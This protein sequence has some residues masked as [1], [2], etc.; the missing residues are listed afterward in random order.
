LAN[1]TIQ[2]IQSSLPQRADSPFA[3]ATLSADFEQIVAGAATRPERGFASFSRNVAAPTIRQQQIGDSETDDDYNSLLEDYEILEKLCVGAEAQLFVARRLYDNEQVVLKIYHPGISPSEEVVSRVKRVPHDHVVRVF[4]F[5]RLCTN[6]QFFEVQE[7]ISGNTLTHVFGSHPLD[8]YSRLLVLQQSLHALAHLHTPDVEGFSIVHRDI[9]PDNI[10]FQLVDGTP[11]F[12]LCDFGIA[13]AVPQDSEQSQAVKSCTPRYAAPETYAGIISIKV[14]FWALGMLLLEAAT[15]GHPFAGISETSIENRI[16]NNWKPDFAYVQSAHWRELLD[17]LLKHDPV[18][19]WGHAEVEA[20]LAAEMASEEVEDDE[21]SEDISSDYA[22]LHSTTPEELAARLAFHW[23][24][25]APLLDDDLFRRWLELELSYLIPEKP[26]TEMLDD[27]GPSP[28]LRLLRLVYRI[29]TQLPPGWK[30]WSLLRADF[31]DI[32]RH[33][34]AGNNSLNEM[35]QELFA[36]DVLTEL[37]QLTGDS[38][39]L[40]RSTRWKEAVAEFSVIR[41]A[42]EHQG[43]PETLLPIEDHGLA[44]LYL[45]V[46]EGEEIVFVDTEVSALHVCCYPWLEAV[47]QFSEPYSPVQNYIKA[48]AMAS[49]EAE[50]HDNFKVTHDLNAT[51]ASINSEQVRLHGWIPPT[52]QM[53]AEHIDYYM[54]VCQDRTTVAK[55]VRLS[56]N[57]RRAAVV[58]LTR[59]GLVG[60]SGQRPHERASAWGL[61]FSVIDYIRQLVPFFGQIPGAGVPPWSTTHYFIDSCQCNQHNASWYTIGETTTFSLVAIGWGGICVHRLPPIVVPP[62]VLAQQA[63]LAVETP[64]L[65]DQIEVND[66]IPE[67]VPRLELLQAELLKYAALGKAD[68]SPQLE[69]N[70]QALGKDD[71]QQQ[72]QFT[73]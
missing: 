14:D 17:G 28:D 16:C 72:E 54:S 56:W 61:F 31:A 70:I 38:D 66:E 9:K 47:K 20:W 49:I 43:A 35:V 51:A 23:Y 10:I 8:E 13:R 71:L 29:Y 3:Q 52:I 67:F 24:Q 30:E 11:K 46:C 69:L 65:L 41:K 2:D 4:D 5:G 45:F 7:H 42:M 18:E 62:P 25:I 63:Q 37:A 36:L 19:R 32:C 73:D 1:P 44:E 64:E 15:G 39:L 26:L 48:V 33:A 58:Y 57:V 40:S 34:V 21:S 60:D 53:T 50:H 68:L 27:A 59:F 12:M 6:G 55:G 22:Y